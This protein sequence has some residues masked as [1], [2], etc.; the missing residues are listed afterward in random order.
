MTDNNEPIYSM[1]TSKYTIMGDCNSCAGYSPENYGPNLVY[2]TESIGGCDYYNETDAINSF[3]NGA[4]QTA[5]TNNSGIFACSITTLSV[6]E[7]W[8]FNENGEF[9][10]TNCPN[11]PLSNEPYQPN[12]R[13]AAS[14]W[15]FGAY[16]CTQSA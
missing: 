14:A 4:L 13:F 3:K 7:C 15:Y 10:G 9:A 11:A 1:L 12:T 2:A 5:M 8:C 16:V 6:G